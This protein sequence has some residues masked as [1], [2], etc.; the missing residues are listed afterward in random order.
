MSGITDALKM[1]SKGLKCLDPFAHIDGG[2]VGE[3][4]IEH[5]ATI[6][7]NRDEFFTNERCYSDSED[8]DAEEDDMQEYI[9][10]VCG[11]E[12]M[13]F[14]KKTGHTPPFPT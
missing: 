3:M 4:E 11:K 6:I 1:G 9:Q 13:P 10:Q 12:T 5:A 14:F 2:L 8:G 7:E